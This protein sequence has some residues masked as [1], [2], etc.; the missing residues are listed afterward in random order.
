MAARGGALRLLLTGLV[1]IVLT[2]LV[3]FA[4]GYALGKILL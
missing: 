4:V 1:A 2:A 3:F